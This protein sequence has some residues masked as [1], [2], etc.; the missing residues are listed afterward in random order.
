MNIRILVLTCSDT[1]SRDPQTDRSGPLAVELITA[2][3]ITDV[4]AHVVA[5]D[6]D[7]IARVISRA[8][9]TGVRV[10][11]CT[12]GTGLG[13][14]DVT[15]QA[16]ASL[17]AVAVPGIGEL[18]R[19][20][21]RDQIPTTDLSRAGA[22][23]LHQALIVALPGSPGGVRDGWQVV[24]PLVPH[25]VQMLAGGGHG[26]RDAAEVPTPP[27]E[28]VPHEVSEAPWVSA[29]PIDV[30]AVTA[31]VAR[32]DAGAVVTFEGRV[33]D[34]DHG[35]PVTALTYEGHPGADT[36]L[37]EVVAEALQRPGVLAATARHRV[38]DLAIGDLAYFVSVCAAHRSEAFDAGAWLVDTAKERLPIWK[39]QTFADGTSEWVNCP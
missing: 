18:L 5:D 34:H 15:P 9:A 32:P 21:A 37:R 8:V 10:V 19:S 4:Q 38:G 16:I 14:R 30:A 6:L 13:P 31:T 3:G 11:V 23:T 24:A 22:W 35:R 27:A 2:S 28:S 39:H 1:A 12:G 20:T 33:R 17:G 25:A 36:I 26:T 7:Q 29:A